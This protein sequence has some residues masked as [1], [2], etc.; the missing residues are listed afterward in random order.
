MHWQLKRTAKPGRVSERH[1]RSCLRRILSLSLSLSFFPRFSTRRE[2]E[3]RFAPFDAPLAAAH[4]DFS[5]W[6]A[7]PRFA[8]GDG[9]LPV[10]VSP[11]R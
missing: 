9:F 2:N 3:R 4:R 5:R 7:V 10:R 8:H 1:L 11:E 6:G